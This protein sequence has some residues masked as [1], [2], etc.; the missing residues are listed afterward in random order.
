MSTIIKTPHETKPDTEVVE[1]VF[2]ANPK[3]LSPELNM[4]RNYFLTILK[5]E[6]KTPEKLQEFD[7]QIVKIEWETIHKS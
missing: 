1:F 5:E 4:Y 3:E 7:G 6:C 2:E